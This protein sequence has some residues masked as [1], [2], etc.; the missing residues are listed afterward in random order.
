[1]IFILLFFHG[2]FMP[3]DYKTKCF[4][5]INHEHQVRE[6]ISYIQICNYFKIGQ[7]GIFGKK[8]IFCI[9]KKLFLFDQ[10]T[11]IKNRNEKRIPLFLTYK[12]LI[13]E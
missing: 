2:F 1:M 11:F 8:I 6:E 10:L 9:D 12:D 5:P 3:L 4:C 7:A 13:K